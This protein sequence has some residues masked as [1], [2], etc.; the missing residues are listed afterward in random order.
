MVSGAREG[1]RPWR[2]TAATF[3]TAAQYFKIATVYES[4]AADT[5]TVPRQQ[6]AAFIRK[7]R[8]FHM[9]A[10]IKAAKEAAVVLNE[11]KALSTDDDGL[12]RQAGPSAVWGPKSKYLT[13]EERLKRAKAGATS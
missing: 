8:W 12:D 5:M 9:L 7:A 1:Q 3:L 11:P 4:A 13:L 10:R 6:R 2:E